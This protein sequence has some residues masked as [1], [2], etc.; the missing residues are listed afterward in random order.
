MGEIPLPEGER[1]FDQAPS[2]VNYVD[3]PALENHA[4][5]NEISQHYLLCDT[6]V[7][8][9]TNEQFQ[10]YALHV[11]NQRSIQEDSQI[12]ISFDPSYEELKI[13][14]L[15]IYRNGQKIDKRF[16]SS[17]EVFQ[18]ELELESHL[19]NGRHS[20]IILV[21]DVRIGDIISYSY[22]LKGN[23]PAYQNHFFTSH[24]FR[25]DS[26]VE[27]NYFRVL[28]PKDRIISV[29]RNGS[30]YISNEKIANNNKEWVFDIWNRDMT[31]I[32]EKDL[33][34]DVQNPSVEMSDFNS[35][36]EVASLFTPYY[37][38]PRS[39]VENRELYETALNI[40]AEST[41]KEDKAL[42]L[43]QFVQKEIRYFGT[44]LGLNAFYPVSPNQILRKRYGECKDKFMM[45]KG[46][47]EAVELHS[48]PLLVSS[49][50]DE[51]ILDRLPI[52]SMFDHAILRIEIDGINYFV[53]PSLCLQGGSLDTLISPSYAYGLTLQHEN[54]RLIPIPPS[55]PGAS[56]VYIETTYKPGRND[57]LFIE[58]TSTYRG[59]EADATREIFNTYEKKSLLEESRSFLSQL[60]GEV[61]DAQWEHFDK[62]DENTITL[63][64]SYSIKHPKKEPLMIYPHHLQEYISQKIDL[65]Q[66]NPLF[67][68]YPKNIREKI[69][70]FSPF[71]SMK[72]SKSCDH[73]WGNFS[74]SIE[75]NKNALV[76]E[77]DYQSKS[78]WIFPE[79][80]AGFRTYI[81]ALSNEIPRNITLPAF[82]PF[83]KQTIHQNSGFI[84]LAVA[85]GLI[86][87]GLFHYYRKMKPHKDQWLSKISLLKK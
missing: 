47:L 55:D 62:I 52:P 79:E 17:I 57:I 34:W 12:E 39:K 56:G 60:F 26:P 9:D 85:L 22:T 75:T 59:F 27:R 68:E 1:F 8:A 4:S 48:T 83:R 73:P 51:D 5:D 87:L 78:N 72:K 84:V 24:S 65:S 13:N 46:L 33:S 82:K 18:R 23:H 20:A 80:I 14:E 2:W 29:Q 41:S 40:T 6:Q 76:M 36:D 11:F 77:C 28:L 54:N 64:E 10:R 16:S 31:N 69:C 70:L 74:Y 44:E 63:K 42:R 43:L 35:W 25:F 53:D 58:K 19:L 15:C 86:G 71:K 3:I 32:D 30:A 66:K 67:Q 45:L 38:L 49:F 81:N 7:R 61:I 37:S 21:D 50:S